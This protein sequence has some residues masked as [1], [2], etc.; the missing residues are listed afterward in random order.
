L[1]GTTFSRR[2]S[3]KLAFDVFYTEMKDT[4]KLG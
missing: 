2:L 4:L 3:T 1:V